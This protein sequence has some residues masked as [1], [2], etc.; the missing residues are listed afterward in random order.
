LRIDQVRIKGYRS[1]RDLTFRPGRFSVLVGPN[2]SGKSNIVDALRFLS[3]LYGK[4]PKHAFDQVNGFENVLHRMDTPTEREISFD[5]IASAPVE[6]IRE[7]PFLF[8]TR[9]SENIELP[10]RTRMR[11]RH[12]FI[13]TG[14][15]DQLV[16][17]FSVTRETVQVDLVGE[18]IQTVLKVNRGKRTPSINLEEAFSPLLVPFMPVDNREFMKSFLQL[19]VS[20]RELVIDRL[21]GLIPILTQFVRYM[22]QIKIYQLAPLECRVPA[23]PSSAADLEIHG[24]NLPALVHHLQ[25]EMPMA[26]ERVLENMSLIV[27]GLEEINVK[28]T[29]ERLWTLEF[30]RS[31]ETQRW[32]A[33]E[34]SDGTVRALALLASTYDPRSSLLALEEPENAVHPWILRVFVGACR[35]ITEQE[36]EKQII[37]TTHSPVLINELQP[38]E[39][40]VVWREDGQTKVR[41]LLR[42][43]RTIQR[44]WSNGDASLF[45]ILDSGMVREVVPSI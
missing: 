23:S 10:D 38:D 41:P 39:I 28:P 34:I 1:L 4:N 19:G 29:Q 9:R 37:V 11:F 13:L 32:S 15:G 20:Q 27:S 7:G 30:A 21:T 3:Q 6:E 22:A 24:Q 2:N 45:E 35:E 36:S 18:K 43:D 14:L 8:R 17:D 33:N 44:L 25:E 12:S 26:W 42:L 31:G 16:S 5:I 40:E